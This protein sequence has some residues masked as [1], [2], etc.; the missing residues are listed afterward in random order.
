MDT[1]AAVRHDVDRDL[2]AQVVQVSADAVYT[3]DRAG[4]ITTWNAAAARLYG[5]SA[6]DAVGSSGSVLQPAASRD[7]L[8]RARAAALGG[9][10]VERF[11]T[12]Q[13]RADGARVPVSLTV[14]PLVDRDGAVVGTATSVQDVTER[15][16]LD[17][18]LEDARRELEA[19]EQVL[20]RS[21]RD[22][23]QFAYVASHDLSEPLR[24]I[25]GYVQ[26]L[27]RRYADVLDERGERYVRHVVEGCARMRA[28]I[29]DLLEYSRFLRVER[30]PQPVDLQQLV[31]DVVAGLQR[32][33][34]DVGGTVDVGVLPPVRGDDAAVRAVVQN[35]V[36]N[37]L[38]FRHEG[39][40]PRVQVRAVREGARVVLSVDDD[41]I[42]VPPEFRD[43][44]FRMFQRLHVR[45]EYGGTGIGL[46][47]V[48]KV[49]EQ[50]G[51]SV[52][53]EQSA[54]GGARFCVTLPADR[55]AR[56]GQGPSVTAAPEL[57]AVPARP[58]TASPTS[59]SPS[60]RFVGRQDRQQWSQ[61]CATASRVDTARAREPERPRAAGTW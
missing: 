48:Q 53:I 4:T 19:R 58:R 21:N 61:S 40:A 26:L 45:E 54:L 12:V 36:S 43:K 57:I 27:E 42:G 50:S 34:D 35:L 3:Q 2:L 41:G 1:A 10:R 49:A 52:W 46:A 51:G 59:S 31:A 20:L 60:R 7:E 25:T 28:L 8:E 22:L 16:L 24:V 30:E 14:S 11:D 32:Q 33:V 39:A 44:V 5:L 23:E 37:A 47:V 18:Q 13:L 29:D 17:A 55:T 9:Q 56:E 15:V 6:T 38:K